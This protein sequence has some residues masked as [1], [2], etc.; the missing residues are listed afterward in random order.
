[1]TTAPDAPLLQVR[2]LARRFGAVAA[3]REV[4]FDLQPGE[5]LALIGPSGCG[6][7][8]T[9]RMIAGFEP[10]D[11]GEIHLRGR[12]IEGLAPERRGIGIV[13]Q[14][15]ALFPHLTVAGNVGF[16]MPQVPRARRAAEARPFVE[17]VGLSGFESRFPDQL[18]GG[19]QQ[20]VALARAFAARP[21][22]IL[23]DEPF[24]NLDAALRQTTRREIRSLLKASGV[25][26]V[27][28]THDQEEALSFADRVCV[29]REGRIEQIGTPDEVYDRPATG[30]VA[31]FLGRTNLVRAHARGGEVETP[32]GRAALRGTA[33]GEVLLSI[34]P[35]HIRL[36]AAT[37]E[38]LSALVVEREFKGHDATL[39]V[40]T[41][42]G[43]QHLVH[44]PH[45]SPFRVGDRVAFELAVAD[46]V[47]LAP[48]S[49]A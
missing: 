30:F 2:G 15:Y 35:E 13:F 11:A 32:F 28:V 1:M 33:D 14:D 24:S 27:F 38:A 31:S 21:D 20:R 7:S 26:A 36:T 10:P 16:A 45:G 23:L 44:A 9:L 42:D 5:I 41:P 47:P 3:V 49:E 6:K 25:G 8:T 48:D 43:A 4:G 29:M 17:M 19:Q 22:A 12:R 37:S 39:W 46:L 40:A 34:R 18:S